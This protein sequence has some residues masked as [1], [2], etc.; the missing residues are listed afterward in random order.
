MAYG[1]AEDG[2]GTVHRFNKSLYTRKAETETFLNINL[3]LILD[4]K[5]TFKNIILLLLGYSRSIIFN[6]NNQVIVAG[7]RDLDILFSVF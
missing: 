3:R 5:K 4:V 6:S 1:A 7:N 2:Y